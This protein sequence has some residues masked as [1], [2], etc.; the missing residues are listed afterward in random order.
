VLSLYLYGVDYQRCEMVRFRF[1]SQGNARLSLLL[2]R[3][4][5][6]I[7]LYIKWSR[8]IVYLYSETN[9]KRLYNTSAWYWP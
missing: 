1:M 9:W 7:Y 4:T 5:T 6:P 2:S 3:D 8:A